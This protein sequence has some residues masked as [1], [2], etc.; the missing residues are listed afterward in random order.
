MAASRIS[1]MASNIA[2]HSGARA[3]AGAALQSI[4]WQNIVSKRH[5]IG[6]WRKLCEKRMAKILEQ[7][8]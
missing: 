6:A 8:A 1:S 4:S 7:A 3:G 5:D 2:Y